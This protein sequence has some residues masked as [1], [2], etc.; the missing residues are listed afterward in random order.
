MRANLLD[1]QGRAIR[2]PEERWQHILSHHS[3]MADKEDVIG[4]TLLD[5]DEIRLD[6]DDPNAVK[7]YYRWFEGIRTGNRRY[8]VAVKFLNGDAF[9]LTS[10]PAG[11][12]KP[13]EII[14]TKASG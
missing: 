6:P 12:R 8:V 7:L 13:G 3:I 4:K 9:V 1:Y 10:C 14:W 11:H 2:F 5:P